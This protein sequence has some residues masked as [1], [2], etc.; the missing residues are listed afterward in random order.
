MKLRVICART[1][2]RTY[3][4]RETAVM[5]ANRLGKRPYP[6]EFCGFWH[7]TSRIADAPTWRRAKA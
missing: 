1:G 2:K 6:C 7:L 3:G 5:D 4:T